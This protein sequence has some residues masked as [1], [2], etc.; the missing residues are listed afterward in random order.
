MVKRQMQAVMVD[1]TDTAVETPMF[2][3]RPDTD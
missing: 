1:L 3:Q 2:S